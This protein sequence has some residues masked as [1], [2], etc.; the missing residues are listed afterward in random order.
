MGEMTECILKPLAKD[1][2]LAE[3]LISKNID[4]LDFAVSAISARKESEEG[5][6]YLGVLIEGHIIVNNF[7]LL[8]DFAISAISAR[9]ESGEG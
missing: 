5:Y 8:K 1:A 9:K 3:G 4:Q 6:K 7:S 2:K